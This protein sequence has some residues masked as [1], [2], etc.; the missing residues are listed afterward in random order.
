M[1]ATQNGF[2]TDERI[3]RQA[4]ADSSP[5]ND[6]AFL[7]DLAHRVPIRYADVRRCNV[8]PNI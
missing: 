1:Q 8:S 6:S 2:H 5:R 7:G 4:I 3:R